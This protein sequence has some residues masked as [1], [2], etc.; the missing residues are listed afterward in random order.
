ML[1]KGS[2]N[3]A[4]TKDINFKDAIYF[5]SEQSYIL[6]LSSSYTCPDSDSILERQT[7]SW[8]SFL[9]VIHSPDILVL[10]PLNGLHV[11]SKRQ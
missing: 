4:H 2:I 6:V 9:P 8:L 5:V 3:M 1:Q 7:L 11:F 10:H